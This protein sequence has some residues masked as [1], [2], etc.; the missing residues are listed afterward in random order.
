[1]GAPLGLAAIPELFPARVLLCVLALARRHRLLVLRPHIAALDMQAAV[2]A[3]ADEDAGTR[4]LRRIVDHGPILKLAHRRL[5]LAQ[6]CVDLL[7]DFLGV[8]VLLLQLVQLRLESVARFGLLLRQRHLLAAQPAQPIGVAV[9]E[10]GGDLDPLPSLGAD[11]LRLPLQLC[12]DQ[13]VE[14]RRVLQPAA[15]VGLEQVAQDDAAG[16]L[17]VGDADEPCAPVGGPHRILREHPAD[18]ARLPD[19]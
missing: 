7:R 18:L 8:S 16:H 4:D 2:G 10:V 17:I 14:Q 15:V 19:R 9:G 5:D 13:P 11:A 12:G 1:M 3:D 6:A